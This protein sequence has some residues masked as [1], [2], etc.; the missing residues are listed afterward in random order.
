[1]MSVQWDKIQKTWQKI[2]VSSY[3]IQLF[4]YRLIAIILY[5]SLVREVKKF[6]FFFIKT[7]LPQE[8]LFSNEITKIKLRK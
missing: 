8:N 6:G 5:D 1:M 3:T 2:F 4:S 7:A